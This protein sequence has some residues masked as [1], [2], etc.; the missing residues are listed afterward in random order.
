MVSSAPDPEEILR[1]YFGYPGFRPGQ[2]ELV[3]AALNGTD[4]LGVL[5]TGGGKSVCYQVP[6]LI[7]DGLTVVVS[8][9]VSLMTDQV[10][11]ARKAGL[12]AETLHSGLD[13]TE[14]AGAERRLRRGCVQLLLLAPER[15]ASRGFRN[16]LPSLR[17]SL[18]AVDE[19]HCISM[20]GHDFRPSYG[21]LGSARA[22]LGTPI[23]ALTATAT[24][25]VRRDIEA[26]L[27][28]RNP[29]RVV[30][31]FDRANLLWG[32]RHV[33]EHVQ[34]DRVIR[35]FLSRFNG[36]RL[37]YAATRSRVECIR[38]SLARLGIRTEAYHAGLAS[39]ERS[40]VQ[41]YFL[42]DPSPVVVATN[43]FGMEI[44][45]ADVRL[46]MHDQLPGSIEDYYQEVGRAGHDG[47]PALCVALYMR[48][49]RRLHRS[50]LDQTHPP[51]NPFNRSESSALRS[52]VADLRHRLK[53]RRV[54]K[55][56]LRGISRYATSGACRRH[57]LLQ[58]FGENPEFASC[59][60]CDRC[61]TWSALLERAGHQ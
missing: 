55:G 45:R 23:V 54:G 32:V 30:G 10:R 40:R 33:R 51:I 58:W 6:A 18:L 11:R 2:G 50:F 16:L 43:A 46:V 4:A 44:D 24:P 19:A 56:K 21:Q 20:W 15:F 13:P 36:A 37:V 41:E 8:P 1:R 29:L 61:A 22:L 25:R 49:D 17:A 12:R 34:K 5:P 38:N 42:S 7:L 35:G 48:A 53:L 3:R 60:A 52:G 31:S 59:G 9:L 39:S 27:G 47:A 26:S 57:S 14:A 28:M